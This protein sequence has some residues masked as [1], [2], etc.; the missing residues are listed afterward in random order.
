M[1][2][3]PTTKTA[4]MARPRPREEPVTSAQVII[5]LRAEGA[6]ETLEQAVRGAVQE[7]PTAFPDVTA[8]LEHLEFFRP[9]KP[10]PTHRDAEV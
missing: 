6:P 1:I 8:R 9:G 4:A 7:L 5:N 10:Q 3:E 2:S